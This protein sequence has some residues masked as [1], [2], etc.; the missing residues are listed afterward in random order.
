MK[1]G[2]FI[3]DYPSIPPKKM[4]NVE[5]S[6]AIFTLSSGLSTCGSSD[7]KKRKKIAVYDLQT[8]T[9]I[10]LFCLPVE[11]GSKTHPQIRCFKI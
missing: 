5:M 3:D 10:L 9:Q 8:K 1:H 7:T 6:I 11:N 4:E 2:A